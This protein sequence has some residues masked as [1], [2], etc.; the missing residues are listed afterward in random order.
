MNKPTA[1]I[2]AVP[3]AD[4][5]AYKATVSLKRHG[6]TVYP[7]GLRPGKIEGVDILTDKPAL[8][9]VDTVTMYVGPH[10]QGPW[11]DYI[12]SL[13]PKRIIFN[14]GAENPELVELAEAKGIE[15]LDACTLVMLSVGNY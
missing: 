14:P 4:R 3:N 15:C 6:H 7:V 2:G 13:N 10:N 11:I 9:D 12:L 8:K 5:Y 1:I